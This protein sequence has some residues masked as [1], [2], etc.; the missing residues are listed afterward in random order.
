MQKG[1]EAILSEAD[2][3]ATIRQNLSEEA[4]KYLSI[5]GFEQTD[6]RRLKDGLT[7]FFMSQKDITAELTPAE[8]ESIRKPTSNRAGYKKLQ[9]NWSK[10]NYLAFRQRN[11]KVYVAARSVEVA[12]YMG[13]YIVALEVMRITLKGDTRSYLTNALQIAKII[14]EITV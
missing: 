4:K 12:T 1:Q 5:G 9:D 6:V 8:I 7:F 11:N 10:H 3:V 2:F 14:N 13:Q